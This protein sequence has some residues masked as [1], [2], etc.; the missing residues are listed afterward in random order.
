MQQGRKVVLLGDTCNSCAM[1]G[2][3]NFTNMLQLLAAFLATAILSHKRCP[4]RA[5][6]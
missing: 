6:L 2:M 4:A 1:L 5:V 3:A